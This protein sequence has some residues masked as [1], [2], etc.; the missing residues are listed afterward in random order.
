MFGFVVQ[1]LKS[2]DRDSLGLK[3]PKNGLWP[4]F[5]FLKYNPLFSQHIRHRSHWPSVTGDLLSLLPPSSG[6]VAPAVPSFPCLPCSWLFYSCFLCFALFTYQL[7]CVLLGRAAGC[8]PGRFRIWEKASFNGGF[9]KNFMSIKSYTTSEIL[10]SWQDHYEK[11]EGEVSSDMRG[12]L[13]P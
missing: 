10:L 11:R 4:L 6:L 8:L 3:N 1:G 7:F 5:F 9:I 12:V 13:S 2:D